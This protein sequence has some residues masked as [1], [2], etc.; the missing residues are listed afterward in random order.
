M[1]FVDKHLTKDTYLRFLA[2]EILPDGVSRVI[3]LDSD[4]VVLDDIGGLWD[5]DLAGNP[6]GA[7]PDLDWGARCRSSGCSI[8]A[9]GPGIATS[10]PASW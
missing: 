8:S 1:M 2:P 9:S 7:A 10:M 5:I 3:Y 4:L 6:L